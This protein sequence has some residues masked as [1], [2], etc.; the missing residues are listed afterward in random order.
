VAVFD[1]SM[2]ERAARRLELEAELRRAVDRGEVHVH[3][4]PL[5]DL[6]GRRV[7]GFEALMRWTHP[8]LGPVTP[9]EFVPVAE[10]TGM[11]VE[12]G[13]WILDEACRQVARWRATLPHGGQLHV[14]VNVSAR[15]LR[16]GRFATTVADCL[17]RWDLPGSALWLELTESLLLDE[18]STADGTLDQLRALGVRLSIDDFGTGYSSLAYLKRFPVDRLKV[19]RTF[20]RGLDRAGSSDES[21]IAAIVAMADAL[22]MSTLAEGVETDAQAERLHQLGVGAAQG[23]LFARPRPPAEIPSLLARLGVVGG[24]RLRA[25][26]TVA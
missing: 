21:L 10:E 26:P 5:V 2:L 4:Q 7:H 25:V 23:Y 24:P 8:V 22:G 3:Y 19:D 11:I 15:Q 16:T 14:S 17:D 20:V 1:Q 12:L 18:P 9:S 13:A 6:P